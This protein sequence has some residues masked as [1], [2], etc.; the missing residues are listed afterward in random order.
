MSD[1]QKPEVL[2]RTAQVSS[3]LTKLKPIWRETISLESKGNHGPW[4]QRYR[5]EFRIIQPMRRFVEISKQALKNMMNSKKVILRSSG[6][7]MKTQQGTVKHPYLQYV[8]LIF[9]Q[10]FILTGWKPW[11]KLI[12]KTYRISHSKMHWFCQKWFF[13]PLKTW[14]ISSKFM[15]EQAVNNFVLIVWSSH[16]QCLSHFCILV[17]T[18]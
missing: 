17:Q 3:A 16:I 8:S 5:K 1:G 4:Q 18:G 15:T 6:V 13:D 14:F 12:T 10:S 2:S 11:E 7:A 9:M